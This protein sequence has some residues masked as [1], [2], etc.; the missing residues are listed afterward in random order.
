MCECSFLHSVPG[1]FLSGLLAVLAGCAQEKPPLPDVPT[2][3]NS[4]GMRF[5]EIPAGTF[6]MGALD[7]DLLAER[8]EKPAHPV[9]ITESF[10]LGQ[11]EVTQ[12]QYEAVTGENP[13]EFSPGGRGA[14]AVSR[15]DTDQLPVEFVNW[16]EAHRFCE[17]L[18]R[19]PEEV[20]AG[21][22]YRLPTEAEWEYACRAGTTTRFSYGDVHDPKLANF[23]GDVGHPM[24]VG[25]YPP[26]PWGLFDMHGNVLEWCSD[27]HTE[28]YYAECL[29]QSGPDNP[30]EDPTGPDV[31]LEDAKVLRGGG[32]A[33]KAAS[34]S[35]RDNI[36]PSRRG[37]S[38]GFRVVMEPVVEQS[39]PEAVNPSNE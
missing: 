33:F 38:H 26:N 18:S 22:T 35:F 27:W 2:V 14:D 32:H 21:R 20:A 11:F 4:V 15:Y 8:D 30:I 19:L 9:E 6:T 31:P 16:Y 3:T 13:S 36:L 34:A 5:V 1:I 25:S 23:L 7:G 29:E 28:G 39:R 12:A 37:N 24:P 10:W 17:E